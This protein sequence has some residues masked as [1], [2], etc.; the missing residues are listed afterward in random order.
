MFSIDGLVSGL[1]TATIIEGLVSLQQS[2]VERL[3]AKKNEIQVK[4]QAFQGIEGRLLSLRSKMSRLNRSTDSVFSVRSATSS[5][6]SIISAKAGNDAVE[7]TYNLKVT[8]LAKAHQIGSQ[9]FASTSTSIPQGTISIQVGDRPVNE[10]TI[11]SSNNTV[12]GL[13]Q[14][15]NSQSDDISAAIV[16]DQASGTDRILLTSKYTGAANEISV[17]GN[18]APASREQVVPDF[19]GLAIQEATNAAIQLGSGP[20]AIT[21][22]YETN[23]VDGLIAD[24]TLDL[25]SVDANQDVVISVTRDNEKATTAI[26]EFVE[27]YNSLIGFIEEQTAYNPENNVASPLL[28]NR[29]V[30]SL[31]NQLGSMLT[32]AVPGVA[33]GLNRFSQLGIEID[34]T[35]R[36]SL[37][38]SRLESVLNG[39]VEGIDSEDIPRLFGMTGQSNVSGI[40]FILGSTRTVASTTPYEIDILQA[41][42]QGKATATNDLA[43]SIVIGSANKE[44]LI[45][46]D[47]A[48]SETLVLTEGTYTPEQ[49]AEHVQSV[50]NSSAELANRDVSVSLDG[51]KLEISSLSYGTSSRIG[52]LSG[53]ALSDLGFDGSESGTGKDVAGSFIV[54]GVVETATG[55]GRIL[56]GDQDNENTADLQIRVTLDPSQINTGVEGEIVINRGVTSRIDQYL[57]DFLNPSTG[58]IKSI[59][60]GFD[61]RVE[62]IEA[63]IERVNQ[64]SDS[65]REYLIE[66]FSALERVL[67]ELQT[68]SSFLT[69]QLGALPTT[70]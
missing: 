12:G 4:Q 6:E 34:G 33:S 56:I 44:L 55:S 54:D 17:T 51:A 59:N 8:S 46:V 30:S 40:E 28:G 61:L 35:G 62:S 38:S 19:S 70:G 68:T 21:A 43:A 23:T 13:V 5:Q 24:V 27:E 37:N 16:N 53:T 66:Q 65:K 29:S 47:G 15:I 22:E 45:S 60:E 36:L 42:E 63:S 25:L 7:G 10:I 11:D 32:E 2:Q 57:S 49:L 18:Y 67:S 31:K 58:S 26:S 50:I 39:E 48:A 3:N 20:G 9:G 1:D 41:A 14:A 52:S 69:S 64:I